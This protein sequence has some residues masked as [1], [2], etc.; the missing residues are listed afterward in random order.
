MCLSTQKLSNKRVKK[1]P[2]KSPCEMR[3]M[4]GAQPEP[5]GERSIYANIITNTYTV[6]ASRWKRLF[7]E[8][9]RNLN[10]SGRNKHSLA[11]TQ[12]QRS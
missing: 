2:K 12:T 7:V 1:S 11:A 9:S 4:K 10:D 5:S 8:R 6:C 3:V